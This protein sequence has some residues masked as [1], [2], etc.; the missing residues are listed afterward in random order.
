MADINEVITDLDKRLRPFPWY[1]A[2]GIGV[3]DKGK[4]AIF[5]YVKRLQ[6]QFVK[7]YRTYPVIQ[8]KLLPPKPAA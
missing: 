1:V 3:T 6:K 7:R 5:A 4:P 8:K 2:S